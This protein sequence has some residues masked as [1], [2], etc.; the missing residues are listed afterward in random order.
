MNILQEIA[1]QYWL[2]TP[3]DFEEW[4]RA[5]ERALGGDYGLVLGG[6]LAQSATFF[7]QWATD[8]ASPEVL[9]Q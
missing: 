8:H 1:D 6:Y 5:M 3:E 4:L 9:I 2:R 7:E